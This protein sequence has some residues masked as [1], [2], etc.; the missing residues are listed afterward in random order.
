MAAHPRRRHGSGEWIAH[1]DWHDL[2][3]R[4]MRAAVVIGWFGFVGVM[5]AIALWGAP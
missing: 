3:D 1:I 2:G 5:L 4:A